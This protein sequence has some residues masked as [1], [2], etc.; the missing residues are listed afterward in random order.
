MASTETHEL[1]AAW[2]ELMAEYAR[3]NDALESALQERHDLSVTEYEVLQRLVESG[4]GKLRMQELADEIHL[5][6][7]AL[8]RLVGRLE[9]TGLVSRAICDHDRRGIEACVTA[10][11]RAAEKAAAPTQ[12]EVLAA[13]LGQPA[14]DQP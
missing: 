6:Q 13:T 1:Q 8:S 12:R 4:E 5:S 10:A 9:H 2:R 3:V 14:G 7:S 11:G